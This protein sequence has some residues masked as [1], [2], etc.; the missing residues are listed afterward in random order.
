MSEKSFNI[1]VDLSAELII[2]FKKKVPAYF[3]VI[4]ICCM[5]LPMYNV[6]DDVNRSRD[7]PRAQK[8]FLLIFFI[9]YIN[10]CD[11]IFL[12]SFVEVLEKII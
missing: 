10:N 7:K 12:L 9:H 1:C 4:A 3:S 6:I 2:L 11:L 5:I 8:M